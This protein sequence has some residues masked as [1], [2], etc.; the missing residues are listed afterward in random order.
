[1]ELDLKILKPQERV[2]L[3]LRLLYEK[4]GFCK[5]HMG[6]FEEYGLYQEN[7]RFLSSEQVITFTDLDGRLLALKPDVT[8]SIAKNAQVDPGGCG[9]YYYAENVYRPSLESHTFREIS[10]MGLECI[11]AVDG[12]A[13]AQTVSLALQSLALTE[14]EFVL[15]MSH[16]GFVTGL[17]DAVGAPEGIRARLLNCIR[18]KNTH[19]LQRAAAEAGLSRQGIDALCRL[20]ALTGDWESVLAAAE[21]LALNAAMGA[22]LAEL[23][24]LCEMLA[25]QGQTGNL[26]LDLSLVNDMEYYNGLVIQ[27]YLAGLPRAVLKGGRYDPLAEQFRPG[28]KAIGFGLYLDEL[29][30]LSDVPTEETGGKVMLN[31]ALPKGRLGDKVYNLLSGVGYG[32]PENYNETRKLVVENPEAG[33][34]YFLVK[35]SDV[36]IYVEHGAADIGIVGKD[37]LAESGADVYELLDTGLGKCRM[38]VAGPED[39]R[40]DQSR[41]LRVATKFVNIAKAYYAAQGRDIDIIKLNGS[42]ELAPILG[43]SDVIV[44]IVETGTTLKENNLKV[45]TEFMPISARFI[46]NRASYQFKRGEIDTLLQKLTEVTNV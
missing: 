46:A 31:V 19:E 20:A 11:G 45:L 25:G 16:M 30:R 26:R 39:F 35:P 43:L 42:I 23:R 40:E 36:A 13:T 1:M 38:C 3:Q 15:E 44:D 37:I 17:F 9:R 5:Y 21:P 10:Q 32:C 4:A 18:D 41:A 2:S 7:R 28:A 6:R 33:I 34:R 29:D 14:R 12:A 22:A 8:L 27:G 24:T